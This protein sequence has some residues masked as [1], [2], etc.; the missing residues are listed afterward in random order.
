MKKIRFDP[1]KDHVF[2]VGDYNAG[3]SPQALLEYLSLY[4][5]EDSEKP[6]FHLI[7]GNHEW[8]LWPTYPLDNLPDIF[9]YRGEWLD[10]YIAHAGMVSD[11][12]LLISEDIRKEPEKRV[13]AYSLSPACVAE[14]APLRQ[15]IWSRRGLYSQK[16]RWQAWP[17]TEELYKYKACI[18][19]GHTPYCYFV[20]AH[21]GYGDYNLF[22]EKQKIWFSEELCS[23][24][25]DSNIKGK[26]ENGETYRGLS[27]LCLE[28]LEEISYMNNGY[29]TINGIRNADNFVFSAELESGWYNEQTGEIGRVLEAVPKMKRITL[30]KNGIPVLQ[31]RTQH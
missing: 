13:H 19:H 17:R 6:G 18:I 29:L 4:F 14:D 25:I 22:W 11:A 16:S 27:C 28:V 30:D 10:Y 8:E 1:E 20:N 9:V 5:Q 21:M 3:G 23:F 7:R 24:D 2:F 12:F 15:I 26:Q 31:A